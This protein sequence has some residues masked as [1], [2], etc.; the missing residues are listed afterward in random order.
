MQS[1]VTPRTYLNGAVNE[2]DEVNH[3]EGLGRGCVGDREVVERPHPLRY[4]AALPSKASP[5]P[6]S[7]TKAVFVT[8]PQ[9]NRRRVHPIRVQ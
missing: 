6:A 9:T 1:P 4:A 3:C 8:A 2:I 5:I 7:P